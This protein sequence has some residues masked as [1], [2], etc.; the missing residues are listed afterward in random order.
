MSI[1]HCCIDMFVSKKFLNCSQVI[2]VFKEMGGETVPQGVHR[3]GL[4]DTGI[5]H[6]LSE[7]PLKCC[8]V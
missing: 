8:R 5:F 1:D 4:C 7:C 6:R 3:G 2:S